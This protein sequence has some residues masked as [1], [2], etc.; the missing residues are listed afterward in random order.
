[1]VLEF[2]VAPS[3]PE[4]L[5]LVLPKGKGE[6]VHFPKY[7]QIPNCYKQESA[8][9]MVDNQASE[10]RW[11][12]LDKVKKVLNLYNDGSSFVGKKLIRFDA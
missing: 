8:I 9:P 1:M 4:G 3:S 6:V 5:S 2:K 7:E 10:E 12:G 11:L